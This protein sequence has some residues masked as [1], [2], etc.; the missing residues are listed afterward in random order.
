V[1][2]G[3]GARYSGETRAR[4]RLRVGLLV[5]ALLYVGILL[6]APVAGITWTVAK[7]GWHVASDTLARPDVRHAYLL[8]G[9]I[10]LITVGVTTVFGVLVALVV[11]RDSFPGR[12]LVNAIV[13]LPLAVSPVIVG[14]MAVLLFGRGGWF[15]P[16]FAA[17][18]IQV[19]FALP[20]MVLVTVFIC[21]PF[22]IREVA[23]LL[24]ELGTE[25]EDAALTLGASSI[26]T[27]FRVTLPN[28][29]WG[30]L[31]GM[32]LSAARAMGEIGAVLI[33]SGSIQGQTE[34]AT[35]YI[36]RALEER[37]DQAGYLV[38]LTLAGVS[39]VVLAAIEV[40]KRRRVKE[41]ST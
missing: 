18:G 32:A 1:S 3:T 19:I 33:V 28:I 39:I 36:F 37:Q 13:D 30:L 21:I 17:R 6:L 15:E 26:Q 5:V 12:R 10:T 29:R 11:T 25:E 27:F 7:G 23:P 20:S 2:I 31:Y 41:T 4:G 38:A 34:T 24:E 14:L 35:L 8:T 9:V 40:F 16:F 22:V